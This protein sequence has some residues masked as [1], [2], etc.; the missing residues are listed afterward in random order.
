L[1]NKSKFL[2]RVVESSDFDNLIL[3]FKRA[4]G[5][6]TVFQDAQFLQ[7]YFS[8]KKK[9][10]KPMSACVIGLNSDSE[11]VS[12]YGGLFSEMKIDN[13]IYNLIWGVN[14]FTLPEWRGKGIN[15]A[16]VNYI[17]KNNE[18]NGVIGFN[19]KTASFYEK[20][21][22]NIFNFQK[23]ARYVFVLDKRKTKKTVDFIQQDNRR[24]NKL[25]ETQFTENPTSVIEQVVELTAENIGEYKLLLDEK[26][27]GITTI[28][29]TL[30]FLKWRILEN[31]FIK[32]KAFG[33]VEKR[34][35]LAYVALRKEILSPLGY[36]V[37]RI[38][39][40]YGKK[41]CISAL[42][43]QIIME[44]VSNRHIYIDFSMFGLIYNDELIS[45][46]FIKLEND[47]YC[48]LP[49]VTAP[50]ENRPNNEY[51][52]FFSK[53]H[54]NAITNL[55]KENVYFTR[56]D[57]DRDRLGRINQIKQRS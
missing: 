4:Y 48:I 44:S 3:F 36:S 6:Q 7:Y 18:V 41:E 20:I 14:A 32:Y 11:I 22:Y 27:N 25:F 31:P 56:I 54:S 53:N 40:L 57:S 24:L 1:R 37:N 51:I 23:F 49:Q 39:D 5:K 46:G 10:V 2:I 38:V 28:H 30:A 26:T 43:D 52:G 16:I 15:S 9:N 47:D 8:S 45:S 33:Y 19:E 21:G 12:H 50:M 55:S 35:L 29:R 17:N 42:L 13:R 34:R